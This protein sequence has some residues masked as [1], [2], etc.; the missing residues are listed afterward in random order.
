MGGAF[1]LLTIYAVVV[2]TA[3][4]LI[5]TSLTGMMK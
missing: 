5:W 3:V 2:V 4:W 1:A